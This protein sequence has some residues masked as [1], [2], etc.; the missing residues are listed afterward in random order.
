MTTTDIKTTDMTTTD[1]FS[2][3]VQ[4]LW[5]AGAMLVGLCSQYCINFGACALPL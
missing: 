3:K 4:W 2:R 5:L 1:G